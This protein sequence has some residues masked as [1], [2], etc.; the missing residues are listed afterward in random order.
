MRTPAD[1]P[2]LDRFAVGFDRRD[3]ARLHRLWDEILDAERWTEGPLTARFETLW[4]ERHGVGAVATSSWAGAALAALD[5]AGVGPGDVVLCP[6]NTFMATPLAVM[7]LGARVA[8]VDCE[9]DD[10]CLSA[11]DLERKLEQHRPK[12]AVVVH[13]GG[14]IAFRFDRF[15]E[16]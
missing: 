16:L 6:S 8:F 2:E 9:R 13:I 14:H 15:T 7:H 12:A 4:A 5:H 11:D 3:R 1:T 10:L